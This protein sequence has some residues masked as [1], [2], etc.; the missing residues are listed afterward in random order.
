M[1]LGSGRCQRRPA[2][3]NLPN[4]CT[5]QT[6]VGESATGSASRSSRPISLVG[7]RLSVNPCR[8]WCRGDIV[9]SGDAPTHAQS[10]STCS[11]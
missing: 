11:C 3:T 9:E 7:L 2:L 8:A 10:P 5:L 6:A 4:A 1:Y